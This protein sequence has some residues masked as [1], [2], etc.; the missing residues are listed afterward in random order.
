MGNW[1]IKFYMEIRGRDLF[2]KRVEKEGRMGGE[3]VCIDKVLF[4]SWYKMIRG[5]KK[6]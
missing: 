1:F 6:N 4:S 5:L 3:C 2:F